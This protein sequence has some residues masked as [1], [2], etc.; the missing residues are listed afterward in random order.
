MMNR[1]ALPSETLGRS[2]PGRF[3]GPFVR[4][5]RVAD[6]VFAIAVLLATVFLEDGPGDAVAVRSI[7]DVPLPALL[8]FAVAAAALYWR[9]R[10]PI[11]VL[12]VAMVAWALTLGSGYSDLG[13]FA[14]IALYSTG[15][16]AA[17]G[18]RG[19]V[20]VVAAVVVVI[21]D[22]RLDPVPWGEIGF[23][24]LVMFGAWYV[25]RRLRLR[26]E[27][28]AQ[29]RQEQAAEARRIVAE[30]RTHIARE[31]HDVVAHRVSMMTVQA[32]AARM[33]VAD[34]PQAAVEA[35]AA[36]EEAGRQALDELRHL[37][38]VLRPEAERDG[39]GPQPGLAD[40]PRLV[41]QVRE[42]GLD[43]S[44]TDG[45]RAPLPARVELSAYRIVQ[46]ALTNVIKHSGPRT[47][48]EVH[49]RGDKGGITVEVLDN[50]RG[51]AVQSMPGASRGKAA[52]HGIVG[53]RERALLLG[54]S[55][56]AGAG[57]DGG[58]RV[59]A[60]LPTGEEPA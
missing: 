17:D 24:A 27:R 6:A 40:L 31:L 20:G 8:L 9:R 59:A 3:R 14:I 35:M 60:H 28:A 48:T 44:I 41:E 39:L 15:R 34:D 2:V 26:A 49:L 52:G 22:G 56:E 53:M 38:G 4:W 36:V 46:E 33:V 1:T 13:G 23:G 42:A 32:G 55:L 10:R 58:F 47:H 7:T 50:G 12:G 5:P 45:I 29:L 37:L 19:R 18:W 25:G 16:Y 30:E 57:P 11:A 21:V 51:A 54:G 43:V